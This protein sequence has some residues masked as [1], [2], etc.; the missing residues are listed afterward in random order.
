MI[1]KSYNSYHKNIFEYIYSFMRPALLTDS[2][3][4]QTGCP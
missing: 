4:D 3:L 2:K 1:C